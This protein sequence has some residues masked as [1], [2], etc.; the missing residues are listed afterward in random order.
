MGDSPF[1]PTTVDRHVSLVLGLRRPGTSIASW[2][3]TAS[4]GIPWA[5]RTGVSSAR[6]TRS[7]PFVPT[8]RAAGLT[9]ADVA[10]LLVAN[11]RR[12]LTPLSTARAGRAQG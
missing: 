1:R 12:A 2:S 11:H 8:L 7:S 4:G 9:D 6:S 3:R 5:S 10:R